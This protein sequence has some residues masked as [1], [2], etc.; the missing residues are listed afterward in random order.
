[1]SQA[2]P[3]SVDTALRARESRVIRGGIWGHLNASRLP[4]G[5]P[6]FFR[7][8]EGCRLQDVDGRSFIDFHVLLG[9]DVLGHRHPAVE[10]RMTTLDSLR[11]VNNDT[12]GSI[13]RKFFDPSRR[14]LASASLAICV[15]STV[16]APSLAQE[17]ALVIA[18]AFDLNSLDP[19][20]AF[21]DTCQIYLSNVY[22][23]LV[24]LAPDNRTIVPALATAW[25]ANDD[26]TRFTFKLD[27]KAA[28]S[29]GS[30]VKA[31][32]VKFSL[33]RLKNVGGSGAFLMDGVNSIESPDAHTVVITL[34][35]PNSEFLGIL[36][37]P[38]AGIL[39][40]DTAMAHGAA[41]G[42]DAAKADQAETWFQSNSAGSGPYMLAAYSADN[43]LRLTANPHYSGKTPA[44][45]DA[46]LRNTKD[47]VAQAQ[48]L[49]SGGAD[50]AMQID[51]DTA[52]RLPANKVTI[53][54]V[55]SFNF[56]YVAISPG[57]KDAPVPL[58]R[59]VREAIALALDYKGII[60]FTVGGAG[61]LQAAPIPNG[62][63]G[64]EELPLPKRDLAR[65]KALLT[66]AGHPDGFAIDAVFPNMNVYGV[67]LS[68]LMQKVQ[69]DLAEVGI[70]PKLQPV[71]FSVWRERVRGGGIPLTAVFYAPDYYGSGQYVGYFGMMPDSAWWK[72]AGGERDPSI[73]N[74]GE[75]DLLA[76]ARAASDAEAVKLYHEAARQMI[77]DRIIIPVVSPNL[78]LAYAPNVTGVRY[79]ACCNLRI[80]EISRK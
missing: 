68:L 80:N 37:A 67:D 44:I 32:D 53:E 11:S 9:P 31:K 6:Q 63:P 52:K 58:T 71:E 78:V 43:E 7:S 36:T 8:A 51:P 29:D 25:E 15:V 74:P 30:P 2:L 62:F 28:F 75:A 14:L 60:E 57:S 27:P 3:N 42:P 18:R 34:D 46:I 10:L 61:S 45:K 33:E 70:R 65:A 50:I 13:M 54:I 19:A 23:G 35:K 76:R 22:Q 47:A 17:K 24:G 64:T 49:E 79:S 77:A 72:R 5:Y 56:I 26:Q 12:G 4:E 73:T 21:C 55:P 41:A 40:A 39:N 48:M 66:K 20:R 16:P 59:E 69:Q 38:Y 1:M